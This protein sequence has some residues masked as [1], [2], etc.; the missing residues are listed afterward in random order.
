VTEIQ[1]GLATSANQTTIL[2]NI[3]AVQADTDDIQG[4]LPAA[5]VA[6]RID[7]SVGA[8][9]ADVVTASAIA[10][11]AIGSAELAASAVTEIQSGLATA[12]S[13]AAL[14]DL[15]AAE[16]NAEVVDVL[17]VDQC[18][19]VTAVPSSTAT[20]AQM[21]CWVYALARNRIL[22]SNSQQTLKA[23]NDT[24]TIAV[25]NVSDNGTTA[26]REKWT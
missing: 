7:A 4:R 11:D 20:I 1:S 15:S 17:T 9:A 14:N 12:A 8:M 2:S 10:T 13:I 22:Q 5:L 6:G 18:P 24:T 26:T 19:E 25:A 16:V 23:D 3:A 21:I